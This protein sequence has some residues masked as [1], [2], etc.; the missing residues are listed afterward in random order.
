MFSWRGG[1]GC[2]GRR[3]VSR[4]LMLNLV[5]FVKSYVVDFL[6][7]EGGGFRCGGHMGSGAAADI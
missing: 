4:W 3:A 5:F 2:Q 7:G 1:E 6:E